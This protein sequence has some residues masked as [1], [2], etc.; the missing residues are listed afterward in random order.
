MERDHV[1]SAAA[2]KQ[3]ALARATELGLDLTPD[4]IGDVVKGKNRT[5]P[6]DGVP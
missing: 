5:N 6:W 1:P 3:A 4:Q 2:M